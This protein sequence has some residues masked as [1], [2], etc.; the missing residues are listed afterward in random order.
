MSL[1]DRDWLFTPTSSSAW[2]IDWSFVCSFLEPKTRLYCTASQLLFKDRS[3]NRPCFQTLSLSF[4]QTTPLWLCRF[5]GCQVALLVTQPAGN[6]HFCHTA[7]KAL[8]DLTAVSL[9]EKKSWLRHLTDQFRHSRPRRLLRRLPLL[10]SRRLTLVCA[11]R[12]P[13]RTRLL[14]QMTTE[15]MWPKPRT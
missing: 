5:N 3:V 15:T 6:D 4:D 8:T 11:A 13:T 2:N 9:Y 10:F 12:L 1:K 14:L 7:R